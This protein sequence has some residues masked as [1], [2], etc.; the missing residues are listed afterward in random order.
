MIYVGFVG[1]SVSF[2]TTQICYHSIKAAIDICKWM[3][4]LINFVYKDRSQIK[5]DDP[6]SSRTTFVLN[7]FK[8]GASACAAVSFLKG[9]CD[10]SLN[11]FL[12]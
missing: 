10:G 3:S 4:V 7:P 5:F 6:W 9:M 12:S 11:S 8:A 2:T 1:H